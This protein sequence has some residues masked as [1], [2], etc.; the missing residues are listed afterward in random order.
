M[1]YHPSL[2]AIL[3]YILYCEDMKRAGNFPAL[4]SLFIAFLFFFFTYFSHHF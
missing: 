2:P 4:F 1:P 3:L